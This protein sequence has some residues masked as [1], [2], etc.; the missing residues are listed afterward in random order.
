[1]IEVPHVRDGFPEG[2]SVLKALLGSRAFDLD[3]REPGDVY[4]SRKTTVS[5]VQHSNRLDLNQQ[6]RLCQCAYAQHAARGQVVR[7]E[8][9]VQGGH[10][11]C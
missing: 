1:V 4:S 11:G 10:I 9:V 7:I 5:I 3:V 6:T 8:E 2:R